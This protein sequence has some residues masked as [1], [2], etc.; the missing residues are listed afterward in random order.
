[1]ERQAVRMSTRP[2][3][4]RQPEISATSVS[5]SGPS[6]RR[7]DGG[8]TRREEPVECL[9]DFRLVCL[10]RAAECSFRIYMHSTEHRTLSRL[11]ERAGHEEA[12]GEAD[13]DTAEERG[14]TGAVGREVGEE[15]GDLSCA[16]RRRE[17]QAQSE[18]I[19]ETIPLKDHQLPP[20]NC[21]KGPS[22]D[23]Y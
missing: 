6:C 16:E 20:E 14:D 21:T 1:M 10:G 11:D 2:R 3:E 4:E 18:D 9:H 15:G 22:S 13:L 8:G 7:R 19:H 17:E 5:R 23:V 12:V